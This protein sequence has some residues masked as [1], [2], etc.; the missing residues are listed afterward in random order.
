MVLTLELNIPIID[1]HL[2]IL[3][4]PIANSILRNSLNNQD[5]YTELSDQNPSCCRPEPYG[6]A[7]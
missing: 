7:F 3:A 4:V 6:A 5:L 2:K 1:S